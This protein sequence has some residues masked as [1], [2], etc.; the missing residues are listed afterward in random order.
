[1]VNKII[2]ISTYR[3]IIQWIKSR[4]RI[5]SDCK[6]G[7][8]Q[9]LI[10]EAVWIIRNL[11]K[12][13]FQSS[14][15]IYQDYFETKNG[16]FLVHKDLQSVISISPAFETNDIDELLSLI[17][18]FVNKKYKILFIDVGAHVGTY[19]V[20]VGKNFNRYKNMD[21]IAFEPNANNFH[22]DNSKILERNIKLNKIKNTKFYEIGLGSKDTTEVNSFGIITKKLDT[23]LSPKIA[24]RYDVVILKIDIEGYE[25]DALKGAIEFIK[26]SKQVYFLVED[27]VDSKVIKY[28]NK[29][30][31]FY[32]RVSVYNSFWTK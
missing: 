30:Y 26:N 11:L 3:Y 8:F 7:R 13:P 2:R 9:F 10:A 15:L 12:M 6:K 25:V 29:Y 17:E 24:L 22:K 19:T 27:C 21:I 5:I 18:S 1:M 4:L 23:I 20:A 31:K 28:M 32:K 14:F 16:N